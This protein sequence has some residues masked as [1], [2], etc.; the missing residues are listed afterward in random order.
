MNLILF[1]GLL[2]QYQIPIRFVSDKAK[3]DIHMMLKESNT[4]WQKFAQVLAQFLVIGE[5]QRELG[6]MLEDFYAD[7]P[8]HDLEYTKRVLREEL[9][10]TVDEE[11][12]RGIRFVASGTVS[13]TYTLVPCGSDTKVCVKVQHPGV[14]ADI[15]EACDAYDMVKDS[16]VFPKKFRGVCGLFFE[17]L[18]D[19]CDTGIEF[20]ASN[21]YAETLKGMG[22][23]HRATGKQLVVTPRMI[24]HTNRCLVMEYL[25]SK[26]V[27]NRTLR[28]TYEE[29]GGE[30]LARYF[31]LSTTI[32]P[33]MGYFTHAYHLD[34]HPG[35][36][37]YTYD[38]ANDCVQTV[39]YDLGQYVWM[40]YQAMGLDDH[41]IHHLE[42]TAYSRQMN[43]HRREGL[44]SFL[45]PEGKRWCET[46]HIWDASKVAEKKFMTDAGLILVECPEYLKSPKLLPIFLSVIKATS[47]NMCKLE[48]YRG[49]Y[50]P[51]SLQSFSY[52]SEGNEVYDVAESVHMERAFPTD[53]YDM[54]VLCY[55]SRDL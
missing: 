20:A 9:V 3:R 7:C 13:Q 23:R 27:T 24:T 8:R 43:G 36:L 17:S 52:D 28:A 1:F 12:L 55:Q 2:A 40:D 19:Q 30:N 51:E 4:I 29:I 22:M 18:R 26:P 39:V 25:P 14:K 41:T 33:T 42:N 6:Y 48:S 31:K 53:T 37:G 32:L 49:G 11:S 45:S 5:S 44:E 16:Y 38:K 35:N 54:G 15:K 50:I 10:G 47:S 21:Q 46:N 34:L